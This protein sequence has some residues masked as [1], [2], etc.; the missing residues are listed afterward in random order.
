VDSNENGFHKIY[1][2]TKVLLNSPP[3]TVWDR[4]FPYIRSKLNTLKAEFCIN[5]NGFK[6][7]VR[8]N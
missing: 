4:S 2:P 1:D 3:T 5:S 6:E 8:T 7:E